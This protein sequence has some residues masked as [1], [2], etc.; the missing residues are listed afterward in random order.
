MKID[1]SNTELL[2]HTLRKLA[3]KQKAPVPE[4]HFNCFSKTTVVSN[5]QARIGEV[6]NYSRACLLYVIFHINT[7][8]EASRAFNTDF[9]IFVKRKSGGY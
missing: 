7:A 2:W 6:Y 8:R 4:K 1:K 5:H 9:F 3:S